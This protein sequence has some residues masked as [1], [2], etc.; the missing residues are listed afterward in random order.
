M[1]HGKGMRTG[2]AVLATL[3]IAGCAGRGC[4]KLTADPS[5]GTPPEPGAPVPPVTA[6]PAP[7]PSPPLPAGRLDVLERL[8][9]RIP[10]S[11]RL[12]ATFPAASARSLLE[13]LPVQWPRTVRAAEPDVFFKRVRDL[14]GIDIPSLGGDCM[15]VVVPPTEVFVSCDVARTAVVP[16]THLWKDGDA[17]GWIV[18][19]NGLDLW[20]GTQ[21][22]RVLAGTQGGVQAALMTTRG[23][24][25]SLANA[26]P[27]MEA[28]LK[29]LASADGRRESALWFPDP[30]L[31][32]WCS[33]A[34]VRTAV[35]WS[36][37]GVSGVV[38]GENGRADVARVGVDAWWSG[39]KAA[40]AKVSS[41]SEAGLSEDVLK[42]TAMPAT[43]AEIG[44]RG[45]RV[46]FQGQGDPAWLALVLRLDLLQSFLGDAKEG[47]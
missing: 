32:P 16:G 2:L 21:G 18:R 42:R 36:G 8:A 37:S 28:G 44:V 7:P 34:C 4:S 35:F 38:A 30:T 6:Q 43:S 11:A 9:P 29:E 46:G 13:A 12:V 47:R 10:I 27:R 41:S 22:D 45:D 20:V 40:D 14:W 23:A 3:A 31:A 25:P 15:L 19:R 26:L 33:E 39:V 1:N 5:P 24:F 17:S